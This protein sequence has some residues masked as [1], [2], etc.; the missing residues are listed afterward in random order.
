MKLKL[1]WVEGSCLLSFCALFD[2]LHKASL[3]MKAQCH[4]VGLILESWRKWGLEGG[5]QIGDGIRAHEN[6]QMRCGVSQKGQRSRGLSESH[7]EWEADSWRRWNL[8]LSEYTPCLVW[9]RWDLELSEYTP[10]LP[11]PALLRPSSSWLWLRDP[12]QEATVGRRGR[13]W[14]GRSWGWGQEETVTSLGDIS[15]PALIRADL[16]GH[17]GRKREQTLPPKEP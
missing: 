3:L 17:L 11:Q 16:E 14:Q 6:A 8:E 2:T 1:L 4:S 10:C 9:R 7:H 13:D 5:A 12:S 15:Q